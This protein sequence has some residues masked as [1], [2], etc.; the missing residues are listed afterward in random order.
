MEAKDWSK[1]DTLVGEDTKD[2]YK[3]C[4]FMFLART[5]VTYVLVSNYSINNPITC[6]ARILHSMHTTATSFPKSVSHIETRNV[7]PR[8]SF[9]IR[10]HPCTLTCPILC[11]RNCWCQ[12]LLDGRHYCCLQH[13]ATGCHWPPSAWLYPQLLFYL[14]VDGTLRVILN[15]LPGLGFLPPPVKPGYWD[16]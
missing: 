5:V 10:G 4:N 7:P 13:Q 11:S 6:C 12:S 3:V 1:E 16:L 14:S 8:T 2:F 9:W 15:K